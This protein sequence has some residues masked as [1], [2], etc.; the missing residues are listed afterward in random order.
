[1]SKD[2]M[3]ETTSEIM[4]G[5]PR[6]FAK[7]ERGYSKWVFELRQKLYCKAKRDPKYQFYTLYGLVCRE[8][9]IKA[10][11]QMVSRNKGAPG[12]DGLSIEKIQSSEGGVGKFLEDI[13]QDLLNKTYE[14]GVV[15]RVHI[16]KANGKLRPLG[17]PTVKDRVVQAAVLI[18]IEPI[19]E[20]DFLECSYGFRPGRS[21]HEA[22]IEIQKQIKRGSKEAY[23]ADLES[24]FDTI[25]HDKLIACVQ[26]RITDGSIIKLIRQWLRA[27]VVEEPKDGGGPT[28]KR[29]K[30]G[31]PQGGVISPLLANLYLHFFDLIF[32]REYPLG[33]RFNARLIRYADDFVILAKKIDTHMVGIIENILETR[34]GLKINR[35]KTKIRDLQTKGNN[36]EFLGYV[37]RKEKAWQREGYYQNMLPS[38]T[39]LKRMREKINELTGSDR[40]FVPITKV[41]GKLNLLLQGW[42]QYYSLGFCAP[43]YHAIDHHVA[44]RLRKHL[45]RRSQRAYRKPKDVSWFRH[46]EQLGVN[47]L[48]S[49]LRPCVGLQ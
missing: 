14:P 36:L 30:C 2:K 33:N 1:M 12:A 15:R 25:P 27:I 39:T 17:I 20:A 45:Q 9:V 29:P 34:M 23:D 41:I 43:A 26:R 11:W 46:F 38:P 7:N 19:F 16:P 42:S 37:Y 6:A 10:A 13:R 35:E 22:L 31:T 4:E 24:Y 3:L 49:K 32:Q 8:E 47:R 21:G 5:L 18:V 48:S 40:S 44:H 28:Y